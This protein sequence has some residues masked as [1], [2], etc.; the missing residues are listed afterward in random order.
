MPWFEG[1][2]SVNTSVWVIGTGAAAASAEDAILAK[3]NSFASL[4]RGWH[5]GSGGPIE[6]GVRREAIRWVQILRQNRFFDLAAFPNESGEILIA[7]IEGVNYIEVIIETDDTISVVYDINDKQQLYLAR[8]TKQEAERAIRE[9]S[10]KIWNTFAGFILPKSTQGPT[11]SP[12][13]HSSHPRM[14]V[15]LSSNAHALVV[16]AAAYASTRK[17]GIPPMWGHPQYFGNLTPQFYH[18]HTA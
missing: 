8:K 17:S 16:P 4:L 7:A 15:Y 12:V 18:Q 6:E 9:L 13:W 14:E 2:F 10:E 11:D 3:I 5:Y 1:R